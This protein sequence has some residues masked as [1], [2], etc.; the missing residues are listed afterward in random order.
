MPRSWS[1][2]ICGNLLKAAQEKPLDGLMI[3]MN[4]PLEYPTPNDVKV[5]GP[6]FIV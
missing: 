1:D 6:T 5:V 3:D 4:L 2:L